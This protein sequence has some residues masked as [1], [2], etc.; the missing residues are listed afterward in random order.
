M[1]AATHISKATLPTE[2]EAMTELLAWYALASSRPELYAKGKKWY[3]QALEDCKGLHAKL[4]QWDVEITLDQVIDV[5]AMV[6]PGRWWS[7]NIEVAEY[8]IMA[9]MNASSEIDRKAYY[10][11]CGLGVGYTWQ[12]FVKAW[13]YL[14]GD[15]D[16][17]NAGS[18]KTWCFADNIRLGVKSQ[19]ATIDLHMVHILAKTKSR[20]S[21]AP[22]RYYGF[23][24]MIIVKAAMILG[25]TPNELQAILWTIRVA[26]FEAGYDVSGIYAL[27]ESM[28]IV[29]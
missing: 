20:A 19:R 4:L 28:A 5:V 25:L 29:E 11:V 10:S 24:E 1:V 3:P 6:S 12:N 16:C 23:F 21:I 17:F 8:T 27:L 7:E 15:Y 22:G 14:D 13:R 26:L 18:P 9:W 2:Q